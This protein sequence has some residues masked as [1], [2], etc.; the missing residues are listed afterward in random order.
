MFDFNKLLNVY[1]IWLDK[2]KLFFSDIFVY[3]YIRIYLSILLAI[4]IIIWIF[5]YFIIKQIN[6]DQIFLHYNVD[7]GINLIGKASNIYLIP[8]LGLAI[9]TVNFLLYGNI[10]KHKDRKFISHIL[11]VSAL[12]AN[13]VLLI[14]T[15][16]IY[17]INFR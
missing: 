15:A 9:I 8:I 11:F 16:S 17:L 5:C 14:S 12:I 4:N 10:S 13:I 2:S 6:Y 3:L 1:L 7:F